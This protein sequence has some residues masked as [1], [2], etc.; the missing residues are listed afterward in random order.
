M[1]REHQRSPFGNWQASTDGPAERSWSSPTDTDAGDT[2][3]VV[4]QIEDGVPLN[5]EEN[6]AFDDIGRYVQEADNRMALAII[7]TPE[8][9]EIEDVATAW[10]LHPLLAED[11]MHAGQRPKLERY[12]DVLFMVVRSAR[13]IDEIEEVEFSEFHLIMQPRA[14]TVIC[15][16]GRLID[17]TQIGTPEAQRQGAS[18]APLGAGAPLLDNEKLLKLGPE[19]MAYRLLDGVVDGYFPV[20][21]GLQND[22]D[23]IERQ[24][25]SGDPTAAERIYNLSQEVV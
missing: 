22:K 19:A 5:E 7:P 3:I 10:N 16:D 17:G 15:Q 9:S 14:L 2:P 18:D 6:A 1:A 13:Y 23:E 12:G 4:R 20:L 21:D 11:L 25:F 8:H 24:V